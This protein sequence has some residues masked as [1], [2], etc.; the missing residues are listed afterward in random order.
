MIYYSIDGGAYQTSAMQSDADS[1]WTGTIPV[2]NNNDVNYYITATD[3]GQDQSEPKTSMFPYDIDLE[4]MGFVVTD[5]L[6]IEHVQKTAWSSGTTRYQGCEVTLDGVVTADTSQYSS[7]YSS[8]AFQDGTGQWSGLVFDTPEMVLLSRGDDV[9]VTGTIEDFD[10]DWHFKFDGNTR[11]INS[12]VIVN[13]SGNDVPSPSLISCSD[14]ALGV[15]DSD[16]ESY[17]GVLVKMNQVTISMVN[18]FDWTI[19]D[20][21]GAVTLI[22]D[23]MATMLADN[24]M[25]EFVEGQELEYLSGIFNYSYGTFKV[26]IRDMDDIGQA[27]GLND[28]ANNIAYNYSLHD[29]Y[30]NPFN[31]ETHIRFE[32]GAQEN[33]KLLIYDCLLY[34]SP[35]PRDRG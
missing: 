23:D 17:E 8:Y 2:S 18:S 15:E 30:P 16:P 19:T 21:S 34:T 22:D 3:D 11:L 35:S 20:A 28:E 6:T 9:T 26:Q 10:P 33:V 14:V 12:T 32:L 7:G 27:L 31:P 5:N 25:S 24:A 4:Q 13:S 1:L 29:N